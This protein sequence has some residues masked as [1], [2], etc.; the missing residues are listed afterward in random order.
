[1]STFKVEVRPQTET[2]PRGPNVLVLCH[3][4]STHKVYVT[5]AGLA[6]ANSIVTEIPDQTLIRDKSLSIGYA[7]SIKETFDSTS[8]E[9]PG[10]DGLG[11]R[12]EDR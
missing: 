9:Y 11:Y 10:F 2:E 3:D 8:T 5:K 4:L 7:P 1:V 6:P 12:K